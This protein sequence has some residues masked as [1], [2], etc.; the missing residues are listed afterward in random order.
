M[1]GAALQL[2]LGVAA[3]ARALAQ[4]A[5]DAPL[6]GEERQRLGLAVRWLAGRKCASDSAN[7]DV[8]RMNAL[9]TNKAND[10]LRRRT[11]HRT[12]LR[13]SE[14]SKPVASTPRLPRGSSAKRLMDDQN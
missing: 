6:S 12:A 11:P 5:G 8:M 10:M 7:A 13:P 14:K 4:T 2:L 1:A 9:E 3:C